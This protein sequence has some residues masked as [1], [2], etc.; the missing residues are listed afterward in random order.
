MRHKLETIVFAQGWL[1]AQFESMLAIQTD[2]ANKKVAE[3]ISE[4]WKTVSEGLDDI[5]AENLKLGQK[6]AMIAQAWRD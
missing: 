2:D 6:L 1:E 4:M 5:V 3:Q